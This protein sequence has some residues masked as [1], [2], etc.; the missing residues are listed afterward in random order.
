MSVWKEWQFLRN[1]SFR[2][3]KR[4]WMCQGRHKVRR[5]H[6]R[7]VYRDTWLCWHVVT[8]K[9][10]AAIQVIKLSSEC[11]PC[12]QDTC[13]VENFGNDV[14]CHHTLETPPWLGRARCRHFP[15]F[16][17]ATRTPQPNR[18]KNKHSHKQRIRQWGENGRDHN[19]RRSP[20]SPHAH[21]IGYKPKHGL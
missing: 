3:W 15:I 14:S 17:F 5:K 9:T 20:V 12:G 2:L 10:G 7:S 8:D 1:K 6:K 11:G 4:S 18:E 21:Q 13:A 19:P 16:L